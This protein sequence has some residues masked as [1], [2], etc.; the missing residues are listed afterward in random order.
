MITYDPDL[1]MATDMPD[2]FHKKL[3][4]HIETNLEVPQSKLDATEKAEKIEEQEEIAFLKNL[5][6][7]NHGEID[8][9][10]ETWNQNLDLGLNLDDIQLSF[11][12][13][14]QL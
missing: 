2:G 3:T 9:I 11:N 10:Y 4:P 14:V 5:F 1:K 6:L 13:I 7:V 12:M 8:N